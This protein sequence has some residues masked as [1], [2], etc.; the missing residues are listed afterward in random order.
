MMLFRSGKGHKKQDEHSQKLAEL[1]NRLE[2]DED[3]TM[4][5]KSFIESSSQ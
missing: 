5:M 1:R 3:F 4:F 2:I